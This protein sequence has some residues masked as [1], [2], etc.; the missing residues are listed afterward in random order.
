MREVFL[1]KKIGHKSPK[2]IIKNT[3]IISTQFHLQ[4]LFL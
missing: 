1:L 4:I 2:Q 3:H